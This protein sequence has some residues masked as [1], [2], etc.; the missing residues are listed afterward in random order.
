MISLILSCNLEQSSLKAVLVGRHTV[1]L[2]I[3]ISWCETGVGNFRPDSAAW[4][5]AWQCS[6]D[7]SKSLDFLKHLRNLCV[8]FLLSRVLF[9][10]AAAL[11]LLYSVSTYTKLLWML[12]SLTILCCYCTTF[13]CFP[14]RDPPNQDQL[15][16]CALSRMVFKKPQAFWNTEKYRHFC[17]MKSRDRILFHI[18][19]I[20]PLCK[21]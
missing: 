3:W 19:F 9:L 7:I 8:C 14:H 1:H 13:P 18:K 10:A 11:C 15:H 2:N 4:M 17:Q 6:S 20:R 5:P 12:L 16:Y 21:W